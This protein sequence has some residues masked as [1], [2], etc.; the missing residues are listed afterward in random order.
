MAQSSASAI[1]ITP[2]PSTFFLKAGMGDLFYQ[3]FIKDENNG[4]LNG[5]RPYSI[6]T[7]GA[8]NGLTGSLAGGIDCP[9]HFS[10][11]V[12]GEG[13]PNDE[14]IMLNAQYTLF[15]FDF[16][17]PYTYF[18]LGLDFSNFKNND[19]LGLGA[20]LGIGANF[21]LTPNLGVFVETK[22]YGAVSDSINQTQSYDSFWWWDLYAPVLAGIK[23]TL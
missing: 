4:G 3:G 7:I 21:P 17:R 22:F 5:M 6:E 9:D 10:Y 14:A 8:F 2:A 16:I 13:L 23:Y 11:F 1:P 19:C 20:Q 12:S 15:H 18:G